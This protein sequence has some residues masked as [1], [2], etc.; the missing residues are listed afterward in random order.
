M[1]VRSDYRRIFWAFAWPKLR[2]GEIDTVIQVGLVARHLIAFARQA[3][4]G[5]ASASHYSMK[6]QERRAA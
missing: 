1:G 6:V 2:R 4:A 3:T 5:E